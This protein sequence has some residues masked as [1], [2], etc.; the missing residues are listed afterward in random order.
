VD[1]GT[2]DCLYG[3]KLRS[4]EKKRNRIQAADIICVGSVKGCNGTD[5][6]RNEY[7][8]PDTSISAEGKAVE[9]RT[10]RKKILI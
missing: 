1:F 6:L 4:I 3:N 8:R 5:T 2:A 10:K 7:T 9:F